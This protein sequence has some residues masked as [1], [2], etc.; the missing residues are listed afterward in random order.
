LKLA[1]A[2]GVHMTYCRKEAHGCMYI[3]TTAQL[4]TQNTV[5]LQRDSKAMA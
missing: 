3:P 2:M 1:N 4:A 5:A